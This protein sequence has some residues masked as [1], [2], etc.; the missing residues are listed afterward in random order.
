MNA[1]GLAGLLGI[2]GNN[3]NY[4][5]RVDRLKLEQC[6]SNLDLAKSIDEPNSFRE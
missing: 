2:V 3:E 5:Y 1:H 6:E 4:F